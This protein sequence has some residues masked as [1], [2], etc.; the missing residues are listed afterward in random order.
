M[1]GATD[2]DYFDA[3]DYLWNKLSGRRLSALDW[4]EVEAWFNAG[5]PLTAVLSG[6]QISFQNL[7]WSSPAGQVRSMAYC[8]PEVY[9]AWE[10]FTL[11]QIQA[12]GIKKTLAEVE[13]R[14]PD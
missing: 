12:G 10:G 9:H 13:E 14:K 1:C 2:Q 3:V 11:A 7:R 4:A 6:I 8:A 5:I